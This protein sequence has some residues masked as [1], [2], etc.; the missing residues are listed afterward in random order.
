MPPVNDRVLNWLYSVLTN[1]YSDVNR[2]YN[3]AAEAL[4]QYPS[5]SPRTDVYKYPR[6]AFISL[7]A[8]AVQPLINVVFAVVAAYENGVPALLLL[9]SGTLPVQFRGAIYRFPIALWVPHDYPREPPM[10]YVTPTQDMLVRPGQHVSGEGRVYHPYLSGWA[11]YWDKS[12]I[13]DFLTVLR[14]VFA[15]EPPVVAKQDQFGSPQ[16]T[17][18]P[19]PPPVPPPPEE[20]RRQMQPPPTASPAPTSDQAPPPPPKPPKDTGAVNGSPHPNGYGQQ[21]QQQGPP[22]PPIPP[23]VGQAGGHPDYG[24]PPPHSI[25]PQRQASLTDRPLPPTPQDPAALPLRPPFQAQPYGRDS[26]VSPITPGGMPGPPPSR[27]SQPPPLPPQQQQQAPGYQAPPGL[28]QYSSPPPNQYPQSTYPPPAPQYQQ[29]PQQ[30]PPY[31]PTPPSG[32][33]FAQPPPQQPPQPKPPVPDL[34]TSELDVQLPSQTS[35]DIPLPVPPVPPNP[36]KDALLSALSSALVA[37]TT[38]TVQGNIAAVPALRAQGAALRAAH[39]RLQQELDQLQRLDAALASNERVLADAMRE[40]DRA[41]DDARTRTV[42]DVDDT[43]VAP[44]V[45]G[46]QLW[47]LVAEERGLEEA[48]FLLGRGL[49]RGRVGA[50]VFVKQT[51]SLAREQ[52]LKKALIKKIAKGMGLDE[53]VEYGLRSGY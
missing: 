39:A 47:G 40:A 35:S 12:S 29:Y 44:T 13:S 15:K 17:A 2:T 19:A 26:P 53:N 7:N 36:Q 21:H 48:I 28:P 24:R 33:Q 43:L 32:P 38:Q 46:G 41:M 22:R 34:L 52:F 51:R 4:A 42:P 11:S 3:D 16:P 14:G 50:E 6:R 9:L 5:L 18:S 10:V 27:Y 31:M 30:Q 37:Q 49:D 45:V 20:W 8:P 23:A 25:P 1:E